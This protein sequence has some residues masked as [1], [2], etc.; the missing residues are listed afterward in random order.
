MAFYNLFSICY[1]CY[2]IKRNN[3]NITYL[4]Q[5]NYKAYI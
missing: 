2:K 3:Y 5:Y 1:F 4:H